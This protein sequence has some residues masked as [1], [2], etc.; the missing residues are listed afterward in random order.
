MPLDGERDWSA[1][2]DAEVVAIVGVLPNGLAGKNQI[3]TE[4]LLKSGVDSL[5]QLGLKGVAP[6]ELQ[7]SKGFNTTEPHPVLESTRFS[8]NGV[9][10]TRA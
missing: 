1:P 7:P 4:G 2:Q 10:I 8:L 6:N 9:S 5:R 3:M